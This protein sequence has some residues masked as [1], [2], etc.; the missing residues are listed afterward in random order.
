MAYRWSQVEL[1]TTAGA[2]A[3][4]TWAQQHPH[5]QASVSALTGAEMSPITPG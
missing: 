2:S 1:Q 5:S 4:K 3:L